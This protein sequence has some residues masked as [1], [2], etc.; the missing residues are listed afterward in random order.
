MTYAEEISHYMLQ[1]EDYDDLTKSKILDRIR[2]AEQLVQKS[3][4]KLIS[5]QVI[6]SI[7]VST[8]I[9]KGFGSW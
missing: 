4:G 6:A 5:R 3:G 8:P 7:I 9:I 2:K 1:D